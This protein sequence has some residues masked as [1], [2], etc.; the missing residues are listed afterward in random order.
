[1]TI[2]PAPTALEREIA[3][4]L[5]QER[6]AEAGEL[7]ASNGLLRLGTE[8]L[9]RAARFGRAAEVA[10]QGGDGATALRL[11]AVA[12]RR[13]LLPMAA[14]ALPTLRAVAVGGDLL[15]R[16]L[17][18][19]A[20][21]AFLAGGDHLAAAEAF[22]RAEL[23]VLA[24]HA[25]HRAGDDV[26]AARLLTTLR[27]DEPDNAPAAL[28]LGEI[29]AASGRNEQA[30]RA[31][32]SVA[33]HAPERARARALLAELFARLD[34]PL[35][36]TSL[37]Q[38]ALDSPAP[39]VEP[40][41]KA[42]LFGRY[43][44]VKAVSTSPT[45]RVVLARDR[46][47]DQRV[48]VKL[49]QSTASTNGR[50]ALR[51][52]EREAHALTSLRHPHV[53]PLLAFYPEGPAAVFPWQDGGA[54]SDLLERGPLAP[55]Q[56][57]FV[58]AALL[59][60]IAAA[61]AAGILHRDIKPSNVLFDGA[62][63]P[64][65]ADFGAAHVGEADTTVTAGLIGSLAYMA[66]EQLA[67][68]AATARSDLYALGSVFYEALTGQPPRPADEL[69]VWPSNVYP[70]ELHHGHDAVVARLLQRDPEARFETA[71]EARDAIRALSWT[72]H[73]A[74]RR[75]ELPRAPAVATG[76]LRRT[77]SG[78][79]V[80]EL[81]R[82]EIVPLDPSLLPLARAVAQLDHPAF[83]TVLRVDPLTSS[84]W[85]ERADGVELE[86][87][88]GVLD[89]AGAKRLGSAIR[90]LH[91]AGYTHGAID[92]DHV[93]QTAEGPRWRLPLSVSVQST[94]AEERVLQTVLA[95]W[96]PA[97]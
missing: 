97:R 7:C 18:E 3:E 96:S 51:R 81:T 21:H 12:G 55:D 94:T 85:V 64:L 88:P 65:L 9:E 69:L 86:D 16:G 89:E 23:S 4:L 39:R 27:R 56:A 61:H 52:F 1:L 29:L 14:G 87:S 57:A 70:G 74:P 19:A 77:T 50:D 49:F 22:E 68:A 95:R 72:A 43:E 63:S 42:L 20:A 30:V 46:L 47:T 53:L 41:A 45:A 31:L 80:D 10:L 25:F 66:P 75:V 48:A 24:A 67:A 35:A 37:G 92:A 2:A 71:S 26:R 6:I 32:Q 33:E 13:D 54:L 36:R 93:V 15:A 28:L 11:S 38:V 83:E 59:G 79:Y 82:R 40:S 34:L 58:A 91:A 76:R 60:A 5:A 62:R 73:G 84:A 8:Y 44:H 90:A 17:P 78:A